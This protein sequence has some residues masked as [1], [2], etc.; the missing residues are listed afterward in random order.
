MTRR[1]VFTSLCALVFLVNFGRV[2]F[3]AL[4]KPLQEAFVVSPA[5]I[6]VVATLVWIG[7]GL[8]RI[9][10]GYLLT[11]FSRRRMILVSGSSLVGAALLTASA[12]T[13]GV[14]MIGALAVGIASGVYFTTAAPT[15]SELYPERIGGALG[16]HGMASQTAAVA[17]P[18]VALAVLA[19]ATWR[20]VFVLVAIVA[21]GATLLFAWA[22]AQLTFPSEGS[23]EEQ[24]F[25]AAIRRAWPIILAGV[26]IG[27]A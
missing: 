1:R 22:S 10:T 5:T 18:S 11:L 15:I 3:A 20:G 8:P 7:T 2:A 26:A 19:V 9:P 21:A 23:S 17:A 14:L 12:P 27:R 13:V 6:G 16:F 24:D 4:L 25:G